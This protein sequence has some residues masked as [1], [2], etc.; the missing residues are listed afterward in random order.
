MFSEWL[1]LGLVLLPIFPK[2]YKI[3]STQ[4]F[5]IQLVKIAITQVES[6][7]DVEYEN[8]RNEWFLERNMFN[9]ESST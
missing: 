9:Q 1:F 3:S 6:D 5:T 4:G 8:L 7:H 2:K